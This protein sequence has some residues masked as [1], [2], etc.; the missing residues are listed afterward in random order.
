MQQKDIVIPNSLINEEYG[1]M[2]RKSNLT[3]RY[4]FVLR[5]YQCQDTPIINRLTIF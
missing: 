3:Q 4:Q 5:Q 1:I 2:K